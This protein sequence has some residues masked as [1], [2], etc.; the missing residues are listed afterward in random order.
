MVFYKREPEV[1]DIVYH[2]TSKIRGIVEVKYPGSK[3]EP[4]INVRLF[5]GSTT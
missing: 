5:T 3:L 1:G 4:M 2:R